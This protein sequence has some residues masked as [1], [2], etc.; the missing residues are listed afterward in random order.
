MVEL[1]PEVE[2]AV[3]ADAEDGEGEE[4]HEQLGR[5]LDEAPGVGGEEDLQR[6]QLPELQGRGRDSMDLKTSRK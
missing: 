2:V 5:P 3:H 1:V 6:L 4:E